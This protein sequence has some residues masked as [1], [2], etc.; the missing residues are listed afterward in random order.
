MA[1]LDD[2]QIVTL[3]TK[4]L[5]GVPLSTAELVFSPDDLLLACNEWWEGRIVIW[6]ITHQ[7]PLLRLSHPAGSKIAFGKQLF[8][9]CS[10]NLV[11]VWDHTTG[12]LFFQE[13]RKGENLPSCDLLRFLS[14]D[15]LLLA[16][17][18]YQFAIL[19]CVAGRLQQYSIPQLSHSILIDV[20][21]LPSSLIAVS[22]IESKSRT[23]VLCLTDILSG[24]E[25][26]RLVLPPSDEVVGIAPDASS[27][28]VW[29]HQLRVGELLKLP[30]MELVH[31]IPLPAMR[32]GLEF[33][34]RQRY[35]AQAY[36]DRSSNYTSQTGF[37][38]IWNLDSG[39]L[40]SQFDGLLSTCIHWS[41]ESGVLALSKLSQ[42]D[43]D[44]GRNGTQFIDPFAGLMLAKA[45]GHYTATDETT[46][47]ASTGR[48]FASVFTTDY[49]IHD[50]RIM[51]SG[52]IAI[53]D[54]AS[55]SAHEPM[56]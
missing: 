53:T 11:S 20:L 12:G 6:D 1:N 52:T 32:Q 18:K 41:T 27:A 9:A 28:L 39:S 25:F 55:I 35:L 45:F 2:S 50:G 29:R 10:S 54:L 5:P 31:R 15:S 38:E 13:Q 36:Y 23:A 21:E 37:L 22:L 30:T 51:P 49:P 26:C 47:L 46:R 14:G 48:W 42:S 44:A 40:I 33:D 17:C 43:I 34:F 16:G 4:Y 7:N 3:D 19:D 8:A 24:S 56:A